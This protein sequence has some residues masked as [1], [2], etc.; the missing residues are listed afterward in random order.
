[1]NNGIFGNNMTIDPAAPPVLVAMESLLNPAIMDTA[2]E[3][4][5]DETF[6][7]SDEYLTSEDFSSSDE[8]DEDDEDDEEIFL[9]SAN[10]SQ[11]Q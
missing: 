11:V 8:E 9:T 10:Q 3:P 5:D 1:M 6:S 4:M 2:T 7:F